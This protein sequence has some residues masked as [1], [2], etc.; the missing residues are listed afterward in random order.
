MPFPALKIGDTVQ[1]LPGPFDMFAFN[2]GAPGPVAALVTWID[3]D[4][5]TAGLLVFPDDKEPLRRPNIKYYD[6]TLANE[7]GF[8]LPADVWPPPSS[9]ADDVTSLSIVDTSAANFRA[10]WTP[11]SNSQGAFITYR[12]NGTTPWKTP[13]EP[14]NLSGAFAAGGLQ[15]YFTDAVIGVAYDVRVQNI[16]E[17]G[18]FAPGVSAT[19]TATT[20]P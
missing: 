15:Y 14:G 5:E 20:P 19:D 17:G 2:R 12:E 10:S 8:K 13:N 7:N 18:D 3:E 16:C 4:N 11:P 1:Y 9:C 6:A